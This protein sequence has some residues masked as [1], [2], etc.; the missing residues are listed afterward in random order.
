LTAWQGLKGGYR[1][2][3]SVLTPGGVEMIALEPRNFRMFRSVLRAEA[4]IVVSWNWY[5]PA[6]YQTYLARRVRR[7]ALVGVPL[8]HTEEPW[9]KRPIYDRMIMACDGMITLTPHEA[10]YVASRAPLAKNIAAIGAGVDPEVPGT[11]DAMQFRARH[12]LGETLLVGFVGNLTVQKGADTL[13]QA[14]RTVWMWNPD[15]RLVLAGYPSAG[16]S[17]IDQL[18]RSLSPSENARLLLLPAISEEDKAKLYAALDVFA[19]PSTG[20]SFG[21]AYLEAWL[22][23]KPV[24]GCRIA[25]TACVIDEGA[26][27]LLVHPRDPADLARAL[28]ALLADPA[29]RRQM[30]ERGHRKTLASFTWDRIA[31]KFERSY[32]E[33]L[34]CRAGASRPLR[35]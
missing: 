6:A 17:A 5:F 27:G 20:E 19:L 28:Q 11:R 26:D 24:I 33:V 23:R 30:G 25:S 35:A 7:F 21:I 2:L 22:Y 13:V 15:V 9:A 1:S 14:M 16:F 12:G 10:G 4:D 34:C 29:R 32:S 18:C 8:F 3:S 31:E